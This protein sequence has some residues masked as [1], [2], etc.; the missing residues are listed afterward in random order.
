[1]IY[2]IMGIELGGIKFKSQVELK[3]YVVLIVSVV[4]VINK[5]NEHFI[6]LLDLYNRKPTQ[7]L[8]S[9]EINHFKVAPKNVMSVVSNDGVEHV[10][11]WNKCIQA[12]DNTN[13]NNTKSAC[14]TAINPYIEAFYKEADKCCANCKAIDCKFEVDHIND[15]AIIYNDF[16]KLHTI[17]TE[18]KENEYYRK[19]FVDKELE[20]A[21]INYHNEKATLQLLCKSCHNNKSF[22]KCASF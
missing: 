7:Q 4:G 18:F 6:F 16:F 21:F 14:R 22:K 15:F 12:K 20:Q 8:N 5:D 13:E 1:M 10:F 17:P 2:I 3:K 11:S 9:Q 19:E